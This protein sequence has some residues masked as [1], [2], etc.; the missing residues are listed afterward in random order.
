MLD[1]SAE[2]MCEYLCSGDRGLL[3]HCDDENEANHGDDPYPGHIPQ[4]PS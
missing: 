1:D 2:G 3:R 4:K